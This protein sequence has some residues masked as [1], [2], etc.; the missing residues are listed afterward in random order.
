MRYINHIS[1]QQKENYFFQFG[2]GLPGLP[3]QE[4]DNLRKQLAD[5]AYS[6][7]LEE[8]KRLLAA[9]RPAIGQANPV[10]DQHLLW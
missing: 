5:L 4:N 10:I 9:V 1:E 2:Q 6:L 8:V 7:P 3:S